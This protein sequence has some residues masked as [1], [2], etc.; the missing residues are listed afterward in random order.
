MFRARFAVLGVMLLIFVHAS[1]PVSA[2]KIAIEKA[3][4]LPRHTYEVDGRAIDLITDP[5]MLLD[6]AR[7][8]EKDLRSDLETYQ[9]EDKTTLKNYF[10]A[11]GSVAMLEGRYDE[12]RD[13]LKK[14]VEIEDKEA[15][16][17][18]AGLITL[19]W[20]EATEAI[21]TPFDQAFAHALRTRVNELPYEKVEAIIKQQKG[22]FEIVSQP[23]I[24]GMVEG[25]LQPVLDE[26]D[27]VLTKDMA[28]QVVSQ[29]YAVQMVLPHKE[30]VVEVYDEYL[31]ARAV[32]KSDIWAARNVDLS[33]RG[34]LT[35]TVVAVWDSGVDEQIF[36]DL[37]QVWTNT[38]EIPGNGIDD[39][40]NSFV[41]D[42]HGVYWDLHAQVTDMPLYPVDE[43]EDRQLL[44]RRMK[45]L[46]DIQMNIESS[47]AD[48]LKGVMAGLSQEEVK[49]FIEGISA[50]GNHCHGTHVAGIVAEGNPAARV[51]NA[52]IT[53]DHKMI[54]EKPTLEL[55]RAMADAARR[56][57]AYFQENGVRVVN[58]S[59]GG[60]ISD[61]EAAL[62]MH[63]DPADPEERKALAREMFEILKGSL[64]EA[65]SGAPEI[66][67]VAAAG[68]SNNDNVFEEL[69]PSSF[70]LPNMMTVGAV[71]QAGD[72]T[73]FTTF[74]KVDI[75]ANGFN[76]E[77]YV[78]GGDRMPLSGTSMAS[79]NA[80]NLAAKILAVQP[81]LDPLAVRELI[82][83]TADEHAAGERTVR[84]MNPERAVEAAAK[85]GAR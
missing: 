1:T 2:E 40:D 66:L 11:L 81:D 25:S 60:S 45:G 39:D 36:A 29:G 18:V 85:E 6:L 43:V 68:N 83:K 59:W 4:D 80:A 71:D 14:V 34:G 19:A 41:D 82:I 48:E 77:S 73:S 9:I 31:E 53:F 42:V 63:N 20:I 35:E 78:P 37:D 84:L 32:D 72:E 75:Y 58:M 74:G 51:L 50:Y 22:M 79:P 47:E 49:P 62:A 69:I 16:R 17:L 56:T 21:E 76:V 26:S 12:Y 13:L 57:I 5:Q 55:A 44:Q 15:Q 65:M 3:D 27:G 38:D 67:F 64:I 70:D 24:E 28:L 54:P 33:K 8:V 52:R 61:Y 10:Q 23:L 30:I 46:R 7:A